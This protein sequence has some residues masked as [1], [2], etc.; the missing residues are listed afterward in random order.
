MDVLQVN[1]IMGWWVKAYSDVSCRDVSVPPKLMKW[2]KRMKWEA[3]YSRG[4]GRLWNQTSVQ[5]WVNWISLPSLFFASRSIPSSVALL[6][7]QTLVR[8]AGCSGGCS[9]FLLTRFHLFTCGNCGR[10]LSARLA[11]RNCFVQKIVNKILCFTAGCLSA[12]LRPGICCSIHYTPL[13]QFVPP[14]HFK[15]MW[16]GVFPLPVRLRSRW[17]HGMHIVLCGP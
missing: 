17:D 2:G 13:K 15:E 12:L 5:R 7:N 16:L 3:D 10:L 14:R 9:V 8:P 11:R 6:G 1:R 4:D